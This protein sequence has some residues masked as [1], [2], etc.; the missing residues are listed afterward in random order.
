MSYTSEK[1]GPAVLWHL[2]VDCRNGINL[3]GFI[4]LEQN[5]Y[6]IIAPALTLKI[7]LLC[8]TVFLCV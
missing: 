5:G 8:L 7:S 6:C 4:P 2:C 3:I 1:E